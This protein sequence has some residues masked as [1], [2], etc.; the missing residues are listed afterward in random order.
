MKNTILKVSRQDTIAELSPWFDSQLK[1]LIASGGFIQETELRLTSIKLIED[2]VDYRKQSGIDVAVLG[3]SGG[4]DSAL[5]AALF[6]EAGW[7]VKG[8]LLPI[9]QDPVETERGVEVCDALEIPFETIDLTSEAQLLSDRLVHINPMTDDEKIRTGNIRAR[10]RM[11]TLY[12][13]AHAERGLVASTD[14][15][16]ELAAGFW[17][18]HGD[19]GDLSPIQSLWKSWEV[20]VIAKMMGVPESVYTAKPT[21]GLGIND[22]DEAQFGCSYLEWDIMLMSFMNKDTAI[23][24]RRSADVYDKVEKR[25]SRTAFKRYNPA[26]LEAVPGRFESLAKLDSIWTPSVLKGQNND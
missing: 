12:N 15:F 9:N 1:K 10:L 16:S 2:L 3:V 7:K 14:N 4:V 6:K 21:D 24:D 11:I 5:V 17:T 25:M 22:G 20:P 13:V 23:S 8:L 19:V 26:Y 18:L